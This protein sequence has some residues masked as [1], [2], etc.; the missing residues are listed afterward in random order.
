M[1]DTPMFQSPLSVEEIRKNFSELAPALTKD[2]AFVEASRCLYCYDAPCIKACPTQI[3]I[4]HVI[5]Q[6]AGDDLNG[7][8]RT[9]LSENILGGSCGR[10]CPTSVLCEGA[11]VYNDLNQK[12]IQIG[13]LQRFATDHVID[14]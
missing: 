10:T 3:N 6:V 13:R 14:K 2:E 11:C 12:P 9:I 5:R 8:A 4:P 1:N 7:S